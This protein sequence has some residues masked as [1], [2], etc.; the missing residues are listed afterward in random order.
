MHRKTATLIKRYSEAG[1]IVQGQSRSG[2]QQKYRALL[3]DPLG[4]RFQHPGAR[5]ES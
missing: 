4:M 2:R 3:N 1:S 5:V